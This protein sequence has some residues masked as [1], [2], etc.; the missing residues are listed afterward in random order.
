MKTTTVTTNAKKGLSKLK[1]KKEVHSQTK[2]QSFTKTSST[3]KSDISLT[4]VIKKWMNRTKKK[5]SSQSRNSMTFI[6]L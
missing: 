2:E 1:K 6:E 3:L 5:V 4:L